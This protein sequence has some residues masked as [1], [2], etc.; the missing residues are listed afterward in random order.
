MMNYRTMRHNQL[1]PALIVTLPLCVVLAGL[2][3]LAGKIE[4]H[5]W[6]AVYVIACLVWLPQI[7]LWKG[8]FR[9]WCIAPHWRM[10]H[11]VTIVHV[12]LLLTA[13]CL[14]AGSRFAEVYG[15]VRAFL[16]S[17]VPYLLGIAYLRYFIRRNE[18][19]YRWK[20]PSEAVD[21]A[22]GR[23]LGT[24]LVSFAKADVCVLLLSVAFLWAK[25]RI[26]L[27]GAYEDATALSVIAAVLFLTHRLWN[28][29][30]VV[31][32]FG[33]RSYPTGCF[34]LAQIALLATPLLAVADGYGLAVV[35]QAVGLGSYLQGEWIRES[36]REK[37]NHNLK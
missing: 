12:S 14:V 31:D 34:R 21:I 1:T 16:P 3:A 18:A 36:E 32:S 33:W 25:W 8:L 2:L 37:G 30:R 24:R 17:L 10:A 27:T 28:V 9:R 23:F 4:S 19:V 22:T 7:V 13:A 5:A 15:Y 26:P 20:K 35:A 29:G 6:L 11:H